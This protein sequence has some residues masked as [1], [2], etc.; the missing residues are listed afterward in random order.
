MGF[1]D[2]SFL[3]ANV[4]SASREFDIPVTYL[5]EPESLGTAG[6]LYHFRNRI[7][8]G[9]PEQLIVMHGDICCN[10]PLEQICAFHNNKQD[11][12]QS[13]DVTIVGTLVSEE[14]AHH[15]G[16]I[17]EQSANNEDQETV[18][19]P[20]VHYAEKPETVISNL[21]NCGIYVINAPLINDFPKIRSTNVSRKNENP[22]LD[23][24]GTGS[25]ISLSLERDVFSS[26]AGTNRLFVYK[27]QK[28]D[29]WGQ[30]KSPRA[31]IQSSQLYMK[32][33][34]EN[35]P[36][37]LAKQEDMGCRIVGDVVTDSTAQIDPSAKIGPNVTIG[38][39]VI[40][41]PGVRISNSIILDG[42]AIQANTLV[43]YSIIGWN[44]TIGKWCR[45]E[46]SPSDNFNQSHGTDNRENI[47]I[48]G[49][50]VTVN[51]ELVVRNTIVL[52]HRELNESVADRIL[53]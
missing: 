40:I 26:L 48:L 30:I 34:K 15:Y 11:S 44:S 47:T 39:D 24:S 20:V 7:L 1:Y 12:S 27:L 41:G 42:V 22:L 8:E 25:S 50:G 46:G 3:R 18:G 36:E 16:C 49:S 29:F 6:G 17:V 51:H 5:R 2:E 32:H 37:L 10:F 35:S 38:K 53:L 9:N 19:G 45:I 52:Q 14:A 4:A 43:N 21:I 23:N 28:G 31:A 13:K 33:F